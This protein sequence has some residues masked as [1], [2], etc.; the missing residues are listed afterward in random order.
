MRIIAL[1]IATLILVACNS[2]QLPPLTA[3]NIV[4]PEP[5]PGAGNTAAYFV[6]RNN[7]DTPIEISSISSPQF[8]RVSMHE[9]FVDNDVARMRPIS[10]LSIEAG[11]EIVFEPGG[12]HVMMMRPVG[13]L[14]SV[15]L[16]FHSG[17]EIVLSVTA[18]METR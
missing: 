15:T 13:A 2:P 9:T 12:R 16:R 8:E 10:K 7:S 1:L 17:Q 11:G 4:I 18:T 6:L 3:T 14:K 5:A